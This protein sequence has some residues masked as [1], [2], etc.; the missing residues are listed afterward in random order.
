MQ[1]FTDTPETFC[2]E[3]DTSPVE[4]Y[5]SFKI[6]PYNFLTSDVLEKIKLFKNRICLITCFNK[7]PI[8]YYTF[9]KRE[10]K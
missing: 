8:I 5:D 3:I 1:F 2:A 7:E 6:N 10:I 9:I 4:N